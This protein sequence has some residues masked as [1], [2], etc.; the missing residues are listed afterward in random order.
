MK[1]LNSIAIIC[2]LLTTTSSIFAR[3]KGEGDKIGGLRI[4][5]QTSGMYLDDDLYPFSEPMPS[6]YVGI[7]RDNPVIS[8]LS[9]GS[10]LEYFQNGIQVDENNKR[11]LHYLSIP[12]S[13]KAKLGPV[14]VQTGFAPSFKLAEQVIIDGEKNT[15]GN[16]D[17]SMWF[18]APFFIGGGVKISFL[19][20]EA[21]YH[22]GLREVTE[23]YSSR[24][25]QVGA[26]VSF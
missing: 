20:I 21:R 5:Y 19:I 22:W 2:I 14:F 24:Y 12:V 17:K 26:G 23:G 6:F 13:L 8:I 4:G 18:D 1:I 7:F 16:N 11:V 15:P 3:K 25:F 10:G 9:I